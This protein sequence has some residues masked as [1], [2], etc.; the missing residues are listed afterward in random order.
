MENAGAVEI[1]LTRQELQLIESVMPLD[2]AAGTRYPE[3]L[4][5]TVNR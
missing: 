5:N 3:A 2:A 4:M 1:E